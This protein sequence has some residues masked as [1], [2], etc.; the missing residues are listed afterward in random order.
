MDLFNIAK[1]I[2]NINRDIIRRRRMI[3]DYY[4]YD[5]DQSWAS[6]ALGFGGVGGDAMTTARTYILIPKNEDVAYVY[7]GGRFAYE[8]KMNDRFYEDMDKHDMA[9]IKETGRYQD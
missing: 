1:E 2:T 6:T 7:F 5:F 3:E 9:S 8:T 4:L